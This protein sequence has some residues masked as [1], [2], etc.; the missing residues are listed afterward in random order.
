MARKKDQ[1]PRIKI[2]GLR[3]KTAARNPEKH[4]KR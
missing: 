4:P 1:K 3:R 2:K